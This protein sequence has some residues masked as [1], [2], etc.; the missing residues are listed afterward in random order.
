M[1]LARL[2]LAS[3]AATLSAA[4]LTAQLRSS[5]PPV[6]QA[7]LPRLLVANPFSFSAQDSGAAV[8]VGAGLRDK[9][10]KISDRWFKTIQR[11]QMNDALIQ[12]AY[13]VDAVLP[14]V[15]ARQLAQSLNARAMV[16]STLLRGEGN[17]YVLES[18]LAN[19]NDEAGQIIRVV[20]LPNQSFEDFGGKA[21]DSLSSAFRALSDAKQCETLRGTQADKAAESAAKALRV[22]PNHGL[23][24]YCLAQISI[25]RKAPVDTIISHL[26]NATKGDR[27]SLPVWTLLA[28]QYQA[29][30]DSAATVE[31]FQE[32]LK[33]APTNEPLRKEA[34]RLFLGYGRL[35]A[36][37]AV[38]DSGLAIDPANAD[39]WDLK[40]SAC[41]VQDTP[42]KNRC[43]VDALE[44][45]FQLDST[46]ADTV[47]FTKITYAASRP[48][49]DT[50]RFLR[51]ARAGIAKYPRNGTLLGQLAQAYSV[52][53]PIDSAVSVTRQLM[54]VDSSDLTPVLRVS[55]ALA[56]TSVKRAYD[57]L[58]LVP[59]IERMGSAEDKA[60]MG[61]ILTTGALPLLSGVPDYPKA[62]EL[63]RAALKL[64]QPQSRTAQLANYVLGLSVF[65]MMLDTDKAAVEQK[66]CEQVQKIK[67]MLDEAL[68]ALQS[69]RSFNEAI[70]GPRI[71]YLEQVPAR[72][73][74]LTKALC[75]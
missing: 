46:K 39:L 51:W 12:Y 21:G 52:A 70:V 20:Q 15:V 49:A 74:V 61:A 30:G 58:Q 75:K 11:A 4:P 65:Q 64:L 71:Q 14:P 69:G 27:L 26:R 41:L 1:R 56:D 53:G 7:N 25:A 44:R 60:N 36:A 50:V 48:P 66:S 31:T 45:V 43:A 17:R 29:K 35:D 18:R 47:F 3:L 63:A 23:A 34:Y 9:V 8:R 38:A 6:Q 72:I 40:S 42:V 73:T 59:Y 62:S 2:V 10:E 68:P 54:A 19:M 67:P 32:M 5:R 16:V 57:A 24:E 37:E 28:V 13:P 22:Q 33:V 55:Q